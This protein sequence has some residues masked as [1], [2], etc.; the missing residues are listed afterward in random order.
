MKGYAPVWIGAG[1]YVP[2]I[3]VN[4]II[5]GRAGGICF[6][7]SVVSSIADGLGMELG[8]TLRF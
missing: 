4:C 8:F 6:K 2:L 5:L 7:K 3:V 1:V